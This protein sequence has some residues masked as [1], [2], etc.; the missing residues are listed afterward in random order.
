MAA[1]EV[2]DEQ[3]FAG[4]DGHRAVASAWRPAW[5]RGGRV[6]ALG[7]DVQRHRLRLHFR[8]G[9]DEVI[10]HRSAHPI[11]PRPAARPRSAGAM[12]DPLDGD[13]GH[14][15]APSRS[16]A[17]C[18][19]PAT[20]TRRASRLVRSSRRRTSGRPRLAARA[21]RGGARRRA[22]STAC[23]RTST[24]P[25]CMNAVVAQRHLRA[26]LGVA[27]RHG[28][29]RLHE[30]PRRAA[31]RLPGGLHGA[32][33]GGLA[34]EADDGRLDAPGGH[35]RGRGAVRAGPQRRAPGRRPRARPPLAEGLAEMPGVGSTRDG[36]DEHRRLRRGRR[37]RVPRRSRP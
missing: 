4:P 20:A 18:V 34:L 14:V 33:R 15:H 28:V 13:D 30:G 26:R 29:D 21:A 16:A 7:D 6:P 24:A 11:R 17:R 23:A 1:A 36:R 37:V 3:Y 8:P 25:G 32:H 19:R 22:P 10:L 9:G 35:R 31:R 2:G 27:L 12:V 5:P